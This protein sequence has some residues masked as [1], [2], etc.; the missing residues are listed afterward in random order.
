MLANQKIVIRLMKYL[1]D[2]KLVVYIFV[3]VC[4]FLFF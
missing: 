4:L 3:G 1:C 2:S